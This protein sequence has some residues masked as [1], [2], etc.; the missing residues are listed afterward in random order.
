[1]HWSL[2]DSATNAS[3]NEGSYPAFCGTAHE[4]EARVELLI[5]RLAAP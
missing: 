4:L 1:V 3:T 2:A 5:G